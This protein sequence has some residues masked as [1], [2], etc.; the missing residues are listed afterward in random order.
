M[1]PNQENS[2]VPVFIVGAGPTGLVLAIWLRKKGIQVRIIDKSSEPGT[3]SRAI[4]VQAR[5]LEFYRQLGLA[6]KL[7][8]AGISAAEITLRRSGKA[9]AQARF[10]PLGKNMCAFPYLLF[11]P[12]DVHEALLCDE[13]RK[14]GVEVERKTE[15]LE[16]NQT[17]DLVNLKIK[18]SEVIE[19]VTAEYLCGCDGAHSLVRRQMPAE[20]KG[21]TYSQVFF[22]A[23]VLATGEAADAGVQIS[24]SPKDFCIVMPV[25]SKG[26]VRLTGLVPPDSEKKETIDYSDVKESVSRNTGLNVQKVNWFSS[27]HVHHR[28]AEKFQNNRVFLAGDAGHIHSPAGG[29]GM[30]TGI[31]DAVNLAWKLAEVVSG[32]FSDKILLSYEIERMAFAKTLVRTTDTAFKLIASRSMIGSLFRA[33][34]LPHVFSILT[35][36]KP[37]LHFAFKTISQIRIKYPQSPLSEGQAGKIK[38]GD[39]LPWVRQ[40]SSDNFRFLDSMDWQIHV[41]GTVSETFRKS[42]EE[43]L[44]PIHQFEWNQETTKLGFFQNGIYLVRPDGYIALASETQDAIKIKSYIGLKLL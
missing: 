41:Y 2:T 28:V 26:S 13:L 30:N 19:N 4:A 23:D 22:V 25:K 14:L 37:F 21:G 16:F 43:T 35:S 6:D 12:Q 44:I 27:Y 3:T 38:A 20:F 34:L 42:V 8:A 1:T 40:A 17:R 11:C 32:R 31:G 10:G 24:V 39:R 18:K 36:L 29:Q 15:I 33:Y 9:V 7:I 5:T